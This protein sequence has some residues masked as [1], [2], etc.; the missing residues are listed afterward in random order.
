[1]LGLEWRDIKADKCLVSVNRTSNYSHKDGIYT[2]SP[3]TKTSLRTI[4]IPEELMELLDRFKEH[5]AEYAAKLGSQ[6]TDTGRLFT[7]D[8]GTAMFPGTPAL[9]YGR[10]CKRNGVR[11]LNLHS[12]RHFTASVLIN[13]G[14]D[15]K[16]I[17]SYLGHSTP[18]T[19]MTIYCHEFQMARAASTDAIASAISL[20]LN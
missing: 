20:K 17:Q 4:K 8:N 5:Q 2:D 13:A 14:L 1:L 11:Y 3:K 10:F 18:V 19:T 9:Y 7:K 16:T 6:W 12:C 15:P